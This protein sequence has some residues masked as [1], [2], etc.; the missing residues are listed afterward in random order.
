MAIGH[1][2]KGQVVV[3][4]RA[5]S[6]AGG[7]VHFGGMVLLALGLQVG[8]V[9]RLAK[10]DTFFLADLE[11]A[12]AKIFPIFT[13]E[14]TGIE[15]VL[16]DPNSDQRRCFRRG[17]AGAFRPEDL[18]DVPAHFY[19]VGT[20]IT[21]EIDL[22]F[23]QAVAKRGPVALDAQ[24]CLR[25][26]SGD[27]L[28][29]DGWDWADQALPFVWSLKVDDREAQALTGESDLPRAAEILG[30]KGPKGDPDLSGWGNGLGRRGDF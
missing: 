25:K 12:G 23:L 29:T 7:A 26:L 19:Y 9:T 16:P 11:K 27:E 14:T 4:G 13:S 6:I 1:I 24:G 2:D 3:G 17:F 22:P 10:E 30:Q 15:N 18:P 5:Q 8:V 21:D 20:I 28:I